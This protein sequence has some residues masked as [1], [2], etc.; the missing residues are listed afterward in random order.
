ME[1]SRTDSSNLATIVCYKLHFARFIWETRENRKSHECLRDRSACSNV[2]H[3]TSIFYCD[4][5][6]SCHL[7]R[8][9]VWTIRQS[10]NWYKD[11][12]NRA[13]WKPLYCSIFI[14]MTF[15][16]L[17]SYCSRTRSILLVWRQNENIL[18][19]TF[20]FSDSATVYYRIS[21]G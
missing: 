21:V 17:S 14:S 9:H 19:N 7:P 15:V 4:E 13:I 2:R 6:D 11:M 12:Y 16:R 5:N 18:L 3:I 8:R 1:E 10:V 20:P